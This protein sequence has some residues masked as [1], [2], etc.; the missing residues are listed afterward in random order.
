MMGSDFQSVTGLLGAQ[1]Q[2]REHFSYTV[3]EPLVINIIFGIFTSHCCV[4]HN[5]QDVAELLF[6]I[7]MSIR[8]TVNIPTFERKPPLKKKKSN[9]NQTGCLPESIC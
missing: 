5:V 4:V 8:C 2:G 7:M 3:V 9:K 1:K 6:I